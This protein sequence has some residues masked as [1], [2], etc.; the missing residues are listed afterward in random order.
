MAS[1]AQT[2][3]S[4]GEAEFLASSAEENAIEDEAVAHISAAVNA[5]ARMRSSRVEAATSWI[6][7]LLI[8]AK[9]PFGNAEKF[10]RRSLEA[11]PNWLGR[12][13]ATLQPLLGDAGNAAKTN[14][15]TAR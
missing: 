5:L 7:A 10:M 12:H 4:R 1:V 13:Q 9:R 6:F 8:E 15:T 3:A 14:G 2:L 11:A